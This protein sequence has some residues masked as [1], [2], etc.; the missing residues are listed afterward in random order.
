MPQSRL[1]EESDSSAVGCML[2]LRAWPIWS[3]RRDLLWYKEALGN[4]G[5]R[6]VDKHEVRITHIWVTVLADV[7]LALEGATC[8]GTRYGVLHGGSPRRCPA[9]ASSAAKVPSHTYWERYRLL[10]AVPEQCPQR[11]SSCGRWSS[12]A[13]RFA[14]QPEVPGPEANS[15]FR[16]WIT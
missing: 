16:S 15:K 11:R 12:W 10:V 6:A 14:Q 3:C 1:A 4:S 13:G 9:D 2:E 5:S 8:P 7:G